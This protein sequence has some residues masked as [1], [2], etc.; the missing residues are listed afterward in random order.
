MLGS[1]ANLMQMRTVVDGLLRCL[2]GTGTDNQQRLDTEGTGAT[3][4]EIP[5]PAASSNPARPARPGR[6]VE[7]VQT[8][9]GIIAKAA[10]RIGPP[11]VSQIATTSPTGETSHD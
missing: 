2:S 6:R 1:T 3:D 11:M 4:P 7:L 8:L 9:A 5:D 10:N